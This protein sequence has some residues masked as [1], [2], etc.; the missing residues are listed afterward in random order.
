MREIERKTYVL[1]RLL[2]ILGILTI[3]LVPIPLG[4]IGFETVMLVST[5]LLGG[6]IGLTGCCLCWLAR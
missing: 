6:A 4:L 5:M 2:I 3:I 1:G